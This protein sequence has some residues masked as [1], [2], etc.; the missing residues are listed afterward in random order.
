MWQTKSKLLLVL[1]LLLLAWPYTVWAENDRE[2]RITG[3]IAGDTVG[4]WRGKG[5]NVDVRED[6]QGGVSLSGEYAYYFDKIGVGGG[7]M[8]QFNR[9]ISGQ[10]KTF[11]FLPIYAL[12]KYHYP[13]GDWSPYA[14]GQ[15]GVA[16]YYGNDAY[17]GS[18]SLDGGLH[19]G[20]GLGT[21]WKKMLQIELLYYE[22]RGMHVSPSGPTSTGPG[23]TGGYDFKVRYHTI[24]ISVGCNFALKGQ[25]L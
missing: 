16:P 23:G 25:T 14:L 2:Q 10:D 13:I 11:W 1:T 6:T 12:A 3:K 4:V 22:D 7:L 21:M 20:L 5:D 18:D 24:G 15:L 19:W 9:K 8:F 17:K